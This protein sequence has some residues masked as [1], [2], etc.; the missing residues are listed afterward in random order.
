MWLEARNDK[1][2]E[3]GPLLSSAAIIFSN[4]AAATERHQRSTKPAILIGISVKNVSINAGGPGAKKCHAEWQTPSHHLI[5]HVRFEL[6]SSRKFCWVLRRDMRKGL[7]LD[8]SIHIHELVLWQ[9]KLRPCLQHL[10]HSWNGENRRKTPELHSM[11]NIRNAGGFEI[12]LVKVVLLLA[13][14]G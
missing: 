5:Q 3:H 13:K 11:H 2:R 7:L 1:I 6:S 8:G 14:R 9:I 12:L 4:A 10:L